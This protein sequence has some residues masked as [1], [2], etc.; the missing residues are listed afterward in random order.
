[1][2]SQLDP[3]LVVAF[4]TRPSLVAAFATRP[5][6]AV[7]FA[8]LPDSILDWVSAIFLADLSSCFSM[9]SFDKDFGYHSEAQA[10]QV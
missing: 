10:D 2:P 3:S 7:A 6:L 5:G 1:M 8:V 9:E 4:A